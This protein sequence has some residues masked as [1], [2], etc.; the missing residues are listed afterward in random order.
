MSADISSFAERKK[1]IRNREAIARAL[2]QTMAGVLRCTTSKSD[3]NK[4]VTRLSRKYGAE[5]DVKD[6]AGE[7]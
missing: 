1:T 4:L 6:W 3:I 5:D 7:P 2:H